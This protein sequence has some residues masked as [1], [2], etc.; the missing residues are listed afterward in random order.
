VLSI[1]L[2]VYL[3][4]SIY[5]IFSVNQELDQAK[6]TLGEI[7]ENLEDGFETVLVNPKKW[8]IIYYEDEGLIG[9][10]VENCLCVCEAKKLLEVLKTQE[11]KC[12]IGKTGVCES[13]ENIELDIP[14]KIDEPV[15]IEITK[16]GDNYVIQEN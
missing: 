5:A 7:T 14:I 15:G 3:L 8:V 6:A 16:V 1:A 11:Q 4:F 2:L 13:V 10:C 12:G 9:N